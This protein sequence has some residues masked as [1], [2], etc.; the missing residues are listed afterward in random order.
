MDVLLTIIFILSTMILKGKHGIWQLS[1][2]VLY[3]YADM[4]MLPPSVD[5][6]E[7]VLL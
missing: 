7:L 4:L 5:V 6:F 1:A 2:F 3:S